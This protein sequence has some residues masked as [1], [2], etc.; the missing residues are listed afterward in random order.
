M[1]PTAA[2]YVLLV[3]SALA[4]TVFASTADA[5]SAGTSTAG[6]QTACGPRTTEVVTVGVS[7][8][9]MHIEEATPA[10]TRLLQTW[11]R[12]SADIVTQYYGRFPAQLVSERGG[13]FDPRRRRAR[14]HARGARE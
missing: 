1:M 4:S 14:C 7:T 2:L 11:V 6:G 12:R 10:R 13:A 8:L 5:S 3:L 9:C